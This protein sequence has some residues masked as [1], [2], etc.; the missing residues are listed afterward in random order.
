MSFREVP[1]KRVKMFTGKVFE[2][3]WSQLIIF[4]TRGVKIALAL[5][6]EFYDKRRSLLSGG[7]LQVFCFSSF[8][9]PE[10]KLLSEVFHT[11]KSN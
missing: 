2:F 9:F 11:F 5:S 7:T 1:D 4:N 10:C 8:W 3:L 6:L